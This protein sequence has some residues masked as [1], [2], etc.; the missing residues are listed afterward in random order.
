MTMLAVVGAG[1]LLWAR[2]GNTKYYA[3]AGMPGG[4]TPGIRDA[5]GALVMYG[6]AM[7][8]LAVVGLVQILRG[9]LPDR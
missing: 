7:I 3:S 5:Y 9:K 6:V 8:I 1:L 2:Y 4:G